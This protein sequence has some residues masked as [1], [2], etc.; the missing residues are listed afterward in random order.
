M[1]KSDIIKCMKKRKKGLL[2]WVFMKD[3]VMKELR[4]IKNVKLL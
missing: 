3:S 4:E 2:R 1:G